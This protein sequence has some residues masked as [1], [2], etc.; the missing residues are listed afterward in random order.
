MA[1]PASFH[2]HIVAIVW[3]TCYLGISSTQLF[4]S[5]SSL[6]LDPTTLDTDCSH[7][8]LASNRRHTVA[9]RI[10][11]APYTCGQEVVVHRAPPGPLMRIRTA[12]V[13]AGVTARPLN[14]N[15]VSLKLQGPFF[16]S[17]ELA[18]LLMSFYWL[19]LKHADES[20]LTLL[21]K[22]ITSRLHPGTWTTA[23]GG[24]CG[25]LGWLYLSITT[26]QTKTQGH[27]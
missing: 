16:G 20:V 27:G 4:L 11:S 5:R 19:C 13:R 22:G 7:F 21:N 8:Q 12:S 23:E 9:Y 15:Y 25:P 10:S 24:Q 1:E 14:S 6:T 26:Q 17:K 3:I 2:N 18:N